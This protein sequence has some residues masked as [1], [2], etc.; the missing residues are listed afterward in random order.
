[1]P[2]QHRGLE[3]GLINTGGFVRQLTALIVT[4]TVKGKV[5]FFYFPKDKERFVSINHSIYE[6]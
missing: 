4:G 6:N 1:M 5:F 2:E 3:Q